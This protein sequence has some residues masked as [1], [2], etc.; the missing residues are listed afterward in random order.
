MFVAVLEHRS[1]RKAAGHRLD[2]RHVVESTSIG[3]QYSMV[4]HGSMLS[5]ALRSQLAPNAWLLPY[6]AWYSRRIGAAGS[7][8]PAHGQY[9]RLATTAP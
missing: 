6:Q 4:L 5:F 7:Q 9:H 2:R 1:F 8:C 3:F